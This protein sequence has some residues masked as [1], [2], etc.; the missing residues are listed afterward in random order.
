MR[1]ISDKSCRE[2]ENTFPTAPPENH[3]VYE[4]MWKN[5]VQPDRLQMSIWCMRIICWVPNAADT[6]SEYVIFIA[7]PRLQRLRERVLLLRVYVHCLSCCMYL[8]RKSPCFYQGTTFLERNLCK[9]IRCNIYLH[10]FFTIFEA[11]STQY[12]RYNSSPNCM[13]PNRFTL[14]LKRK[15]S[16]QWSC[17]VVCLFVCLFVCL[18]G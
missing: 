6:H 12:K 10:S 3:S 8:E 1:N 5:M 15:D 4:T 2:N 16:A 18:V 11:I 13:F 17:L 9:K 14:R 7:F